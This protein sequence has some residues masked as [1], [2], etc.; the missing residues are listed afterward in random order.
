MTVVGWVVFE[1]TYITGGA[2]GD[3][4]GL[5]WRACSPAGGDPREPAAVQN[6]G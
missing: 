4:R 1:H 6:E 2:S 5:F 3:S